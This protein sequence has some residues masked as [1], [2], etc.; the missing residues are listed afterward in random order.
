VSESFDY[1]VNLRVNDENVG[2]ATQKI[3][4]L[5]AAVTSLGAR[6]GSTSTLV[7]QLAAIASGAATAQGALSRL[8]AA[9]PAGESVAALRNIIA[10]TEAITVAAREAGAAQEQSFGAGTSFLRA[11]AEAAGLLRAETAST[12]AATVEQTAAVSLQSAAYQRLGEAIQAANTATQTRTRIQPLNPTAP[13]AALPD[14]INDLS[15]SSAVLSRRGEESI[16]NIQA[17]ADQLATEFGAD[18]LAQGL[19]RD[20]ALRLVGA[21][22]RL[23][24]V[25][26]NEK[27]STQQKIAALQAATK[28]EEGLATAVKSG[29]GGGGGGGFF[30]GLFGGGGDQNFSQQL[31]QTFK[32]IAFYQVFQLITRAVGDAFDQTVQF[33]RSVTNLDITLG[34]SSDQAGALADKL[35]QI[36]TNAGL[37]AA[38]GV[39]AGVSF[40]R[41]FPESDPT[42]AANQGANAAATLNIIGDPKTIEADLTSTRAVLQDF[43]LGVEGTARV[44]DVATSAAQNFGFATASDILPGLAQ[45]GDLAAASGFTLEQ[46]ANTIGAIR[47]KT[48]ESA[49]AAA[50][51]LR[52]F[53]GREGNNAFQQVFASYGIDITQQFSD[54]LK[55][56]APIFNNLTQPAQ[57]Q[58]IGQLGGGRAGAAVQALLSGYEETQK[59]AEKSGNSQGLAADQVAAKLNDLLGLITQLKG[60][61]SALAKDLG[62]SGL[63]TI[64]GI[65]LATLNPVLRGLDDMLKTAQALPGPLRDVVATLGEIAILMAVIGRNSEAVLGSQLLGAVT[66]GVRTVGGRL[67]GRGAAAAAEDGGQLALFGSEAEKAVPLLV[68]F[69][70]ALAA[71]TAGLLAL[72]L[73]DGTIQPFLDAI[74]QGQQGAKDLLAATDAKGLTDAS[75]TLGD[76][77]N[78]IDTGFFGKLINPSAQAEQDRLNAESKFAS[79]RATLYASQTDASPFR[80]FGA[81]GT[82]FA[83]GFAFLSTAGLSA[84]DDLKLVINALNGVGVA[85]KNAAG[86]IQ[87]TAQ[88]LD[89]FA[90][91]GFK[92]VTDE[93]TLQGAG[94]TKTFDQI[95]GF[96]FISGDTQLGQVLGGAPSTTRAKEISDLLANVNPATLIGAQDKEASKLGLTPDSKLKPNEL[97]DILGAG[98]DAG[99]KGLGLTPDEF[100]IVKK[101]Y[102]ERGVAGLKEQSD[103]AAA[104]AQG[105]VSPE[106][107]AALLADKGGFADFV[108]QETQKINGLGSPSGRGADANA[109]LRAYDLALKVATTSGNATQIANVLAQK[110]A[111]DKEADQVLSANLN[112]QIAAINAT[113]QSAS[114]KHREI[115]AIARTAA[116][117]FAKQ[118]PEGEDA[119]IAVLNGLDAAGVASVK[120]SIEAA[121]NAAIAAARAADDIIAKSAAA[122]QAAANYLGGF[123]IKGAGNAPGAADRAKQIADYEAAL[124][125]ID[126]VKPFTAPSGSDFLKPS[127]G[128]GNLAKKAGDLAAAIQES[129]AIPG[130]TVSE[131]QA[132]LRGAQAKLGDYKK[133]SIEYYQALKALHDAQYALATAEQERANQA[134]QLRGDVTDPVVQARDK[135]LADLAKLRY[136]QGRG[137][138]T[139]SDQLSLKQDQAAAEKA[140]FE[141]KFSDE[142]TAYELNQIS[143]QSYINYLESQHNLL[144]AVHKKTRDQIDELNQVDQALKAAQAQLAGQF[145]IGAIQLPTIYEVRR[146]IAA[147]AAGTTYQGSTQ[148]TIYITGTDTAAVKKVIQ[149]VLGPTSSQTRTVAGRK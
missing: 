53:L 125:A 82:D 104:A 63:G 127:T 76:A 148:N 35:G 39:N 5:E 118:G 47:A 69:A 106:T 9:V 15:L 85:G 89:N 3:E 78:K 62:E 91:A 123:G 52:R 94:I 101:L 80:A 81:S 98:A 116:I 111:V 56:F 92:A 16:R 41:A 131:A 75:H 143:Y 45:I 113:N 19:V 147:T 26:D 24:E 97:V 87:A 71:G 96:G 50:G 117:A 32:Y 73:L 133:G 38:A 146:S 83:Q 103:L 12:T 8:V 29:N 14:P 11:Q 141:Q 4:A 1:L 48:G 110:A 86:N 122:A 46:T 99:L 112:Q 107:L 28:A 135:V 119:L 121:L 149:D 44:L 21:Y 2:P 74:K 58:I 140:K 70:P 115:L 18:R 34:A 93:K 22:S 114:A 95:S 145:N 27:S 10:E 124:K 37:A 7:E 105:V 138:N 100:K 68:R 137:A 36:A 13:A 31:G 142:Q 55:Q 40:A 25:V 30:S 33:D 59:A 90:G 23:V 88:N 72:G 64:F 54:E 139:T 129:L 102:I 67:L 79:D 128:G 109:L 132:A 42:L 51:E 130:D 136:D 120:A 20:E 60:D 17:Q 43:N 66:G 77:A 108:T 84:S 57:A 126:N 144:T 65:V 61:F 49:D 134:L 6:S